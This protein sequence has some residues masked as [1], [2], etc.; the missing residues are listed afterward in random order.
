MN[1]T[2]ALKSARLSWLLSGSIIASWVLVAIALDQSALTVQ[3]SNQLLRFGAANGALLQA[4]EW[5][6]LVVSQFLHVHAPHMLFNALAVLLVGA[7]LEKA[8]GRWWLAAIYLVGGCIGQYASVAFYPTLV[9]SGASQA[10][11]AICGAALLMCRT[12]TAYLIVIA[13]LVVQL[14]LD[15]QAAGTVK[16]GHGWGFASGVLLGAVVVLVSR[17]GIEARLRHVA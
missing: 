12:R 2:L 17:R 8:A 3:H 5:W 13:V 10:L 11:M 14:S 4:G 15:L 7:V 6:R 16:A 9:S 1:L